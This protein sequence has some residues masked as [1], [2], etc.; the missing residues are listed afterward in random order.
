MGHPTPS[1]SHRGPHCRQDHGLW[2]LV[3]STPL[4]KGR[5]ILLQVK[6]WWV[7]GPQGNSASRSGT[8]CTLGAGAPPPL[9]DTPPCGAVLNWSRLGKL[10]RS[11]KLNFLICKATHTRGALMRIK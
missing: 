1:T 9:P 5:W 6:S 11:Q 10:L 3:S 8:A 4:E 2:A 7:C